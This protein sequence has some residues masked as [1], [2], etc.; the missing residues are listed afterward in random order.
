MASL[1]MRLFRVGA[2]KKKIQ[3]YEYLQRDVDPRQSWDTLGELGDGAFGKV[4]KVS[5]CGERGQSCT[6]FKTCEL[7]KRLERVASLV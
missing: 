1:L 3:H 2:D 6:V 7:C 5:V 4:Y